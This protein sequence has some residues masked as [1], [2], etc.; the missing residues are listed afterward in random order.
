MSNLHEIRIREF[1]EMFDFRQFQKEL[2]KM[3]VQDLTQSNKNGRIYSYDD[4]IDSFTNRQQEKIED[5][6]RK[7]I[8]ENRYGRIEY[9]RGEISIPRIQ[10]TQ[11]H[12]NNIKYASRRLLNDMGK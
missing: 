3:Y 7:F 5:E 2:V 1:L 8:E 11:S 9:R 10:L 12:G 4:I 6:Y